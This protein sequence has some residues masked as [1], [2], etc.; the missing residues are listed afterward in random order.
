MIQLI[1]PF[2][3][4]ELDQYMQLSDQNLIRYIKELHTLDS[5]HQ[6]A[7]SGWGDYGRR[8]KIAQET[9]E[10]FIAMIDN[11]PYTELLESPLLKCMAK[12]YNSYRW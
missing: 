2:A 3:I 10:R 4:V 8:D 9:G 5:R 6:S 1:F 12:R 11:C 7:C